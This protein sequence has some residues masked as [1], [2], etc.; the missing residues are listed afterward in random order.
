VRLGI[1]GSS[2]RAGGGLTHLAQLL[3]AGDP[4]AAGIDSVVLWAGGRTLERMPDSPWLRRVHVSDLDRSLPGRVA[5]QHLRLPALAR[6]ACDLI[7]YPGGGCVP[8]RLPSVT[9]CQNLLPFSP[10]ERR[11]YGVSFTRLRLALL[12]RAHRSAI[13]AAEG[14]IFLTRHAQDATLADVGRPRGLCKIISHGIAVPFRR[15]PPDQHPLSAYS[16]SRPFRLLYVSIIDLYKHQGT[17]AEATAALRS[18]GLPVELALVG[19]AHPPALRNLRRTFGRLDPDGRFL[20]YRGE[21]AHGDLPRCYAEADA[22]VFA[23]SCESLPIILL[24]A[25]AAGLPIAC[26][27]RGPMPELL[28]DGGVYFDPEQPETVR[29]ALRRLV[30]EPDLR[31][32]L[33]ETAHRRVQDFTWERCAR[34]TFAFLAEVARISD[35]ASPRGAG[36]ARPVGG[37]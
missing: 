19:P 33:A 34:E 25:M 20:C 11:R 1:D 36:P 17:V 16:P 13:T 27:S 28:A 3:R 31:T 2:I 14:V 4:S 15:D 18:E 24:E 29:A 9:M 23:S 10:R 12:R 37:G 22:F 6:G 21:V 30:T 35:P 32:S 7:F 8:S 26:S 5:W